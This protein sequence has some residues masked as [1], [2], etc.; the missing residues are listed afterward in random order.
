M[1]EQRFTEQEVHSILRDAVRL[2]PTQPSEGITREQLERFASEAGITPEALEQS[3]RNHQTKRSATLLKYLRK[4]TLTLDWE[5]SRSEIDNIAAIC[6][7]SRPYFYRT[8]GS[9]DV[10]RLDRVG[11]FSMIRILRRD[12]FTHISLDRQYMLEIAFGIIAP[13]VTLIALPSLM[14]GN[15]FTFFDAH[16]KPNLALIAMLISVVIVIAM[17][18]AYGNWSNAR[19]REKFAREIAQELGAQITGDPTTPKRDTI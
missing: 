16:G 4:T 2:T 1:S 14:W 13:A 7:A 12:G 11:F 5:L 10:I 15:T 17:I 18:W 9:Y 19:K 6:D 3:I 8:S